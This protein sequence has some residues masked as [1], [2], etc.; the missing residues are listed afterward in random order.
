VHEWED[1]AVKLAATL[2]LL[3]GAGLAWFTYELRG[4]LASSDALLVVGIGVLAAL[5]LA[6]GAA[7]AART[8]WGPRLGR[9]SSLVGL[10]VAGATLVVG[11]LM[12]V[13]DNRQDDG[14]GAAKVALA[15]ALL[16][17][18]GVASWANRRASTLSSNDE[19]SP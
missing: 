10:L 4:A 17:V 19:P 9:T 16:L 7:L 1:G 8:A 15:L 5:M 13:G 3:I 12:L 6:S 14:S 11:A 18:F 2:D